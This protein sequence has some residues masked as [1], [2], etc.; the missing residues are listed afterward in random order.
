MVV[1]IYFYIKRHTKS[2]CSI[3]YQYCFAESERSFGARAID[4]ERTSEAKNTF[5]LKYLDTSSVEFGRK[6]P[7]ASE[8]VEVQVA[9]PHSLPDRL[10][11]QS[12]VEE[13]NKEASNVIKRNFASIKPSKT[14]N[15][16]VS[17]VD[18]NT[19]RFCIIINMHSYLVQN[20]VLSPQINFFK[21]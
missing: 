21:I 20:G 17:S 16:I 11:L 15:N 19:F 1:K 8:R 3:S 10:L 14:I 5:G 6:L 13:E 12:E 9:P 18:S 4:D 2:V 7:S